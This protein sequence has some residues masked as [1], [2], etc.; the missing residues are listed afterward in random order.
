MCAEE[1][2]FTKPSPL[3]VMEAPSSKFTSQL[4]NRPPPQSSAV[5]LLMLTWSRV[6]VPLAKFPKY[7]PPPRPV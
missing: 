6:K 5:L 1:V 7:M 4:T 2:A 3:P